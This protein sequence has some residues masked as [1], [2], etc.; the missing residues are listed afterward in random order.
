MKTN[1]D[2]DEY[3]S[4]HCARLYGWLPICKAFSNKKKKLKYLTLCDVQAIDIFMLELEQVIKRDKNNALSDVIICESETEKILQIFQNVRPPL[5]ESIINGKIEQLLL[6]ED[7]AKYK[8]IEDKDINSKELRRQLN[9]RRE[10]LRFQ[11]EFPFDIINFDPCSSIL[12]PK[13]DIFKTIRKIVE[14]QNEHKADNYLLLITTPI[15][16]FLEANSDFRKLAINDYQSNLSNY[17]EIED[18]SNEL[19]DTIN[20]E[21]IESSHKQ[22]AIA[23]GKTIVAKLIK[24]LKL[25]AINH[26]IYVY[27]NKDKR[28]MLSSIVEIAKKSNSNNWYQDEVINIMENMPTEF[29]YKDALNNKEVK[30]HLQSIIQ[31]REK[32]KKEYI[33]EN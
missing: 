12:N 28:F 21:D 9:L 18:K 15:T 26:G 10:A 13:K 4:K 32:I 25:S 31:H 19:F 8:T 5:Q 29:S 30:Q 22:N 27:E 3:Y 14:F 24:E 2:W 33:N 11:K 17:S 6:F 20:F 7:K 16:K 23:F 1:I